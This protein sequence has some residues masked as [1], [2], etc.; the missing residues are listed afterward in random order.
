LSK[1]LAI[2]ANHLIAQG[3]DELMAMQAR[4][5]IGLGEA[6][7]GLEGETFGYF[8]LGRALQEPFAQQL[9]DLGFRLV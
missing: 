1:L 6:S 2:H 5:A 7:G 3:T 9:L 4:E 8:V